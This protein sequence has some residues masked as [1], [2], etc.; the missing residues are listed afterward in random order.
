[1]RNLNESEMQLLQLIEDNPQASIS[2]MCKKLYLNRT[3]IT[4][5]LKRLTED[6]LIYSTGKFHSGFCRILTDD[7]RLLLTK[8]QFPKNKD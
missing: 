4:R 8:N 2:I 5:Y 1:M 7:A 3:T 6:K